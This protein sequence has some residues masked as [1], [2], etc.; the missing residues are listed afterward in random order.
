MDAVFGWEALSGSEGWEA[1]LCLESGREALHLSLRA[2]QPS[3]SVASDRVVV[4][5]LTEWS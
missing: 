5:L 1:V 3:A 4:A 2:E